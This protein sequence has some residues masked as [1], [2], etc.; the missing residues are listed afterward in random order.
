MSKKE[1]II[2]YLLDNGIYSEIDEY[3]VD[4]FV[5][6]TDILAQAIEEIRQ[7]GIT[8]TSTRTGF[9]QKAPAVG[10]MNDCTKYLNAISKKLGLSPADRA[11]LKLELYEDDGFI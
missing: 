8:M 6:Y 5:I 11:A 2:K 1:V 9:L 3:L 4:Q 7:H 10:I